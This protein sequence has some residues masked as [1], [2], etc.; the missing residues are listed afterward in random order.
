MKL[1]HLT[2]IKDH[3][4]NCYSTILEVSVGDY[5]KLV[6]EIY[7]NKG[8]INE[9]REPLKTSSAMRIRKQMVKDIK[10]GTILPPIVIGVIVSNNDF[11]NIPRISDNDLSDIIKNVGD[12]NLTIIDGMQ[13]TTAIIEAVEEGLSVDNIIRVE[14]WISTKLNSLIY[15][16]LVLNTGQVPWNIRR[17]VETVFSTM[18]NEIK[19]A[20]PEIEVY[21][22]ND[23]SRRSRGGQYHADALIELYLA[24]GG[25]KERVDT[26][27]RLADEFTRLDFIE[28]TE[29]NSF[30]D[31]YYQSLRALTLLDIDFSRFE[32]V[33]NDKKFNSGKDLFKSQPARVGFITAMAKQIFGRPGIEKSEDEIQKSFESVA[34]KFNAIYKKVNSFSQTELE[35]FL[36]LATLSEKLNVKSSRVG[37]FEREFFTKSFETLFE[38]GENIPSLEVCWLSY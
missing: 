17:Q 32:S 16:M 5:L 28:V 13:R 6:T 25:R 38:L 29:S 20:I 7:K 31:Y 8:G 27:E 30:S 37:D 21:S 34:Q 19:N 11:D 14:F 26:R 24:F 35:E 33:D 22:I 9:Q 4:S 3:R 1:S 36:S 18:I 15:R 10:S 12:G 23:G 2:R